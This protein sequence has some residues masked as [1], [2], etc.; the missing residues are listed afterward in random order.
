MTW[1]AGESDPL[2]ELRWRAEIL[3]A[4]YWM[5]GEGLAAEVDPAAMASFLA[6]DPT[7]ISFHMHRLEL[8]G[9]V[10]STGPAFRLTQLGLREGARSFRDDFGDYIRPAHGECGSSCW[11]RDPKHAGEPCPSEARPERVPAR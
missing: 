8:D 2:E 3:E 10:E 9:Y 6:V 7:S 1:S 5:R 11:C 4:M